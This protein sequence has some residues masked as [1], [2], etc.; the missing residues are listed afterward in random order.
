MLICLKNDLA[1]LC[2]LFQAV[3]DLGT[4]SQLPKRLI[5]DLKLA[6]DEV[7]TNIVS[8]GYEDDAE[9]EIA[10][11]ISMEA[12]EVCVHVEDDARPFNPLD[13][14]HPNVSAPLTERQVGGLGIHLVRHLMDEVDYKR[15]N[16]KNILQLRKSALRNQLR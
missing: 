3:E 4:E 14:P 15:E 5:F 8:Y 12:G 10:V 16:G 2:R 1:E 11:R 6:L 9:H 13:Y 7:F